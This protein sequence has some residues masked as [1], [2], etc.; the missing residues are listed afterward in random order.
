MQLSS[1]LV[2]YGEIGL[3]GGNRSA[4][5]I[6]LCKNIRSILTNIPNLTISR[7]RGRIQCKAEIDLSP[8]A[9]KVSRVFG[10]TSVS[11]GVPVLLSEEAIAEQ[12][13][14]SIR[15]EITTRFPQS[16]TGSIPFKILVNRAN[17]Q[18][19]KSSRQLIGDLAEIVLPKCPELKVD[20]HNPELRLEVDIREEYAMIFSKRYPGV[21]GLPVGTMGRGLCLLSGGIDSP[22][23]AWMAMKRGLRVE[24]ISFYSFPHVGPQSREK[25]IQLAE[26]LAEYQPRTI[27]HIIP[28]A[29]YQEAIRDRCPESY[30]TVLYRRAMQRISSKIAKTNRSKALIT[31]ESLGQVA[32]QTLQNIATIE[33]ASHLPVL[34]PLISMDKTETVAIAKKIGTFDLSIQPAPDCC[35]VFQP[36][37]PVLYSSSKEAILAE[38]PLE[39]DAL[40]KQAVIES[41]KIEITP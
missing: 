28:F 29:P 18:F 39:L 22:V 4:F 40:T 35:T 12:S 9:E 8:F 38:T 37:S 24:F 15:N 25:I 31:G 10:V 41:E 1:L 27:L 33:D 21:G 32:S 26:K 34:R 17:K 11:P 23:A 14:S 7:Q 20:I 5:E 13:L 30:R 3:K 6:Q 36:Q 2:R 19:P 16:I